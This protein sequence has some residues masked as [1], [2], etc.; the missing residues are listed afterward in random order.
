MPD[1]AAVERPHASI[2]RISKAATSVGAAW[3]PSSIGFL[4][5]ESCMIACNQ[6]ENEIFEM[7]F[8]KWKL[9][10]QR[11]GVRYGKNI[12]SRTDTQTF[13]DFFTE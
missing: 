5:N 3:W 10:G 4:Q 6:E 11:S 2:S 8:Q 9:L 7:L 1:D 13:L 12:P